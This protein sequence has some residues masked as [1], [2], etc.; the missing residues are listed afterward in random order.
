[1]QRFFKEITQ[2]IP[3]NFYLL[4][5]QKKKTKGGSSYWFD[6]NNFKKA[7]ELVKDQDDFYYMIG[8]SSED[9]GRNKRCSQ[10][11]ICGLLGFSLDI[12]CKVQGDKKQRFENK[13]EAYKFIY[14]TI[15]SHL[16]PTM[17]VD[18]GHGLQPSWIF[19]EPW[20]FDDKKEQSQ[21]RTLSHALN[22][23]FRKKASEQGIELDST[24]NL[25][26]LFRVPGTF[27]AKKQSE[28]QPVKVLEYT[29]K[30]YNPE[31]FEEFTEVLPQEFIDVD[32]EISGGNDLAENIYD[33]I[34]D[35]NRPYPT[36]IIT[37]L[38]DNLDNFKDT[39]ER[40]RDF[41]EQSLSNYDMSLTMQIL[42]SN[43][44][45]QTVADV[46]LHFRK[47][48]GNEKD[49]K[50]ALR[51][52][53]LNRTIQTAEEQIG[54]VKASKEVETEYNKCVEYEQGKASA[55]P[56]K[57]DAM[58]A[59]TNH[60]GI[61][62]LGVYKYTGDSATY[63][64]S[65]KNAG[66][67]RE[68]KLGDV[69]NLLDQNKLRANLAEKENIFLTRI[70]PKEWDKYSK[71]MVVHTETIES[72]PDAFQSTTIMGILSKYINSGQLIDDKNAAY[73]SRSPFREGKRTF[74][75]FDSFF[76][77]MRVDCGMVQNHQQVVQELRRQHAL[78]QRKNF[79]L[80]Q[81]ESTELKLQKANVYDITE[82]LKRA[83]YEEEETKISTE[84]GSDKGGQ[85]KIYI[86]GIKQT[87]EM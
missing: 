10:E 66:Q 43:F 21:A 77:Y 30:R 36:Q 8:L 71:L 13:D 33:L 6:S 68:V 23:L 26:R 22:F 4:L 72:G 63:Y 17:I 41:K 62:F 16:N 75:F 35:I 44:E 85:D 39:W 1:M 2:E 56:T 76:Q 74:I 11:E 79:Y 25:D 45:P 84:T 5:W 42:S 15:P 7:E 9:K 58:K 82:T 59:L 83:S 57:D 27:N 69:R 51:L 24:Y 12:D 81:E 61:H 47:K 28:K 31:D 37:L 70:K 46:L 67:E 65:I 49:I 18:S 53:Y 55:K 78:H 40:K 54:K 34:I 14:E 80:H 19:K 29:G 60:L 64:L 87:A 86:Q 52:S 3:E 38:S 73:L 20:L 50:K 48:H 32:N